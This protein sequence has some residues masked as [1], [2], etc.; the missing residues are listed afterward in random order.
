MRDARVASR[1]AGSGG[2]AAARGAVALTLTDV[3]DDRI[4]NE[5]HTQHEGCGRHEQATAARRLCT[6]K[7]L[8][9]GLAKVEARHDEERDHKGGDDDED[10][11]DLVCTPG[12]G[13]RQRPAC[14]S[15]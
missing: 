9:V 7:P 4:G 3:G 5:E 11:L 15:V 8:L 14:V 10:K 2:I 13:G 6:P 12:R 1:E